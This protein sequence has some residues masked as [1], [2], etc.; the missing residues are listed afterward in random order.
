MKLMVIIP[1]F[2]GVNV[3]KIEFENWGVVAFVSHS[4]CASTSVILVL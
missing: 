1:W 4:L 3:S 2:L